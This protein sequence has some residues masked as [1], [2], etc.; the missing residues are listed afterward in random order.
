MLGL[1]V[2]AVTEAD[3]HESIA[4]AMTRDTSMPQGRK[5]SPNRTGNEKQ[6]EEENP[7]SNDPGAL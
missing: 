5:G 2:G 6:L 7:N 1:S 4:I 3:G